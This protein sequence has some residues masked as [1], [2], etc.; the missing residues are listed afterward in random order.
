MIE[1]NNKIAQCPS[2]KARFFISEEQLN[3]ANGLARCGDCLQVFDASTQLITE[4]DDAEFDGYIDD[5]AYAVGNEPVDRQMKDRNWLDDELASLAE[6]DAALP[7]QAFDLSDIDRELDSLDPL[8]TEGLPSA[9]SEDDYP[10]AQPILLT[11]EG[12]DPEATSSNQIDTADAISTKN[13]KTEEPTVTAEEPAVSA[14]E[15]PLIDLNALSSRLAK[16]DDDKEA[17][18]VID[19]SYLAGKSKTVEVRDNAEHNN[20]Y[21]SDEASLTQEH[22]QQEDPADIEFA[23][24]SPTL[25]SEIDELTDTIDESTS[26]DTECNDVVRETPSEAR[27]DNSDA[28]HCNEVTEEYVE[29]SA[30]TVVD[31]NDQTSPGPIEDTDGNESATAIAIETEK[32]ALTTTEE[33]TVAAASENLDVDP[34]LSEASVSDE[35]NAPA[36]AVLEPAEESADAPLP[37]HEEDNPAPDTAAE[38]STTKTLN[39]TPKQAPALDTQHASDGFDHQEALRDEIESELETTKEQ[40]LGQSPNIESSDEPQVHIAIDHLEA[41]NKSRSHNLVWGLLNIVLIVS[42]AMG[43]LLL[44][45]DTLAQSPKYRPL[46]VNLCSY[47]ECEVAPFRR[48]DLITISQLTISPSSTK[49]LLKVS[50]S[51]KNNVNLGQPLPK[52]DIK[53]VNRADVLVSKYLILPENYVTDREKMTM[54]ADE[55]VPLSFYIASP[56][57]QAINYAANLTN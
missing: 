19:L 18:Q 41:Q 20:A 21:T 50:G 22:D 55:E 1:N 3:T 56:G 17:E 24:Q 52:I 25:S 51:I 49:G 45:K 43:S 27:S 47:A 57:D 31:E 8:N 23:T 10:E 38:K 32:D 30:P 9:L 40:F 35:A 39:S 28:D 5:L 14:P 7:K 37:A 2:C 54:A 26:S 13:N 48:T 15:T 42:L 12:E 34:E 46:I 16:Y 6:L 29:A 36:D 44:Y 33:A 4:I 53:F 11:K